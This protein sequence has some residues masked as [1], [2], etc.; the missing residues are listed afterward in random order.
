MGNRSGL[1]EV[2]AA[3]TFEGSVGGVVLRYIP[4]GMECSTSGAGARVSV[5]TGPVSAYAP[6]SVMTLGGGVAL[7][8]TTEGTECPSSGVGG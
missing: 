5:I 3:M 6:T 7:R 1:S 4:G 8:L 2:T